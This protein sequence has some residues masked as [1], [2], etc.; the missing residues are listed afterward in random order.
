MMHIMPF[1]RAR[2]MTRPARSGETKRRQDD[3]VIFSAKDEK[4]NG[5]Y[6]STTFSVI[7][8]RVYKRTVR[9]AKPAEEKEFLTAS[10]FGQDV[11]TRCAERSRESHVSCSKMQD[12]FYCTLKCACV[13][14]CR[15]TG[16]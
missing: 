14:A 11:R 2:F 1:V 3:T 6:T 15:W 13:C 8:T 7:L 16:L 12:L 10:V 9:H 4:T 5:I